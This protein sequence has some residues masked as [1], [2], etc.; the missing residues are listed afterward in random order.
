ME[1]RLSRKVTKKE[2][3]WLSQNYPVGTRFTRYSGDCQ[4]RDNC[5]TVIIVNELVQFPRDSIVWEL[6]MED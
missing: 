5:V 1:G 6:R 4:R 2:C 3:P